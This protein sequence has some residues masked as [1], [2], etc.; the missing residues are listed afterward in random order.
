MKHKAKK[1]GIRTIK[2]AITSYEKKTATE[3]IREED[4]NVGNSHAAWLATPYT[5]TNSTA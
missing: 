3:L 2:T 5:T 1:T 4:S